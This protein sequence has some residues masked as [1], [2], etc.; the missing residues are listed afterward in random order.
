LPQLSPLTHFVRLLLGSKVGLQAAPF[1][2]PYAKVS[3]FTPEKLTLVALAT[4]VAIAGDFFRLSSIVFRL[5]IPFRGSKK[6]SVK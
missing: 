2:S 5:A 4:D 3:K 1:H 6:C